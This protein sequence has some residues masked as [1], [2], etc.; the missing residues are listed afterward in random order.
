MMQNAPES[1]PSPLW[2]IAAL[3][4]LLAVIGWLLGGLGGLVVV[5]L[6]TVLS[7]A[8]TP[9]LP[10]AAIMRVLRARPVRP[11]WRG[12]GW[13]DVGALIAALSAQ[14]G[15]ARPPA[16]YVQPTAQP[17][18]FAVGEGDDTAIA[19]SDGAARALGPRQLQAV[20]AH[21]IW[22]LAAGDTRW[23]LLAETQSRVVQTV[24]F[25]GLLAAFFSALFY[26]KAGLTG[27]ALLVLAVS[28]FISRLLILALSRS[29]EFA[30]D[31]GAVHLTGD[32]RSL[33]SALARI[34]Q[35]S[36][37]Q[38]GGAY[39]AAL[40]AIPPALRTHPPTEERI[41]RLLG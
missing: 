31:A 27:A 14:A 11:V 9:R 22:H 10:A 24:A 29:R 36:L 33:A 41:A 38:W 21:E 13:S 26:G 32:A 12:D 7:L 4:A 1:W 8:L 23:L 2:T 37:L 5:G 6:G 30:A 15:L 16:L 28:P 3:A 25:V 35:L 19:V 40:R 34:E 20:L 18:A 39:A 17:R